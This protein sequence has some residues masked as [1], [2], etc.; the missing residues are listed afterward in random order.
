M[1]RSVIPDGH[2]YDVLVI[3]SGTRTFAEL[4]V[5]PA[6]LIA[7]ISEFLDRVWAP[8]QPQTAQR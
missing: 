1:H 2:D 5:S 3:G 4:W 8:V 7:E 6:R